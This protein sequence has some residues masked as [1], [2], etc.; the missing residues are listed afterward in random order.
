MD[1]AVSDLAWLAGR[2]DQQEHEDIYQTEP[3]HGEVPYRSQSYIDTIHA[4]EYFQH[5]SL[6]FHKVG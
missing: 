5:T 1:T 4:K 2:Q 3:Q 6:V